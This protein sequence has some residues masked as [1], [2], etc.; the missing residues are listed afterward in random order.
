MKRDYHI[1]VAAGA[2]LALAGSCRQEMKFDACGQIDAVQVTVSAESSGRILSLDADEGD[3]LEAGETIGAIDSVQTCLQIEEIR[4][5]MEGAKTRIIDIDRQLG[6]QYSQLRS[7]EN[8]L[9][10]Y[11]RLL[12]GNAATEKQVSELKDRIELKKAQIAA[13]KQNW[14]R[15]NMSVRSEMDGY[16]IQIEQRLDQLSKCRIKAPVSGTV[17][18]KYAEAGE[19]VT[20]GKPLIRIADLDNVYVRAYLTAGQLAGMK[21][22]D[23]LCVIPDDGSA[24]PRR[25]EGKLTWISQQAEFTPKNIQTR[26]ERADM[27]YAV[28]VAVPNDG[29]LR[30]GMY[31]YVIK[32]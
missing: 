2:L 1:V 8:D 22:G 18:T 12:Q 16:E 3:R 28:K 23:T 29:S 26:D 17:L 32:Q 30:L 7:L 11:S 10:R 5:R 31:A 13:Q 9:E 4:R 24:S 14:E 25:I 21:L 6:P 20:S 19:S 15:S 27:V